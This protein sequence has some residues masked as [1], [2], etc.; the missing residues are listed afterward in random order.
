MVD[1]HDIYLLG[2]CHFSYLFC[3]FTL[4]YAVRTPR[5]KNSSCGKPDSQPKGPSY[6]GRKTHF[7]K[8][9]WAFPSHKLSKQNSRSS[10]RRKPAK[11]PSK[12]Q[13]S[14]PPLGQPW[15]KKTRR[16]RGVRRKGDEKGID[17]QKSWRSC[18]PGVSFGQ[19]P[20]GRGT[21]RVRGG[22]PRVWGCPVLFVH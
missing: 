22:F 6:R 10:H 18:F 4:Y 7:H 15:Y 3:S 2:S 14:S 19:K 5:P 16:P 20:R 1:L 11:L 17:H 12:F 13:A 8:H 21:A 9:H